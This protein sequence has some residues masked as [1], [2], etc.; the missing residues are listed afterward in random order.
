VTDT[1]EPGDIV[2]RPDAPALLYRVYAIQGDWG[3]FY[4]VTKAGRKDRRQGGFS[5]PMT[6]WE[7]VR[8]CEYPTGDR[9]VK[10]GEKATTM[11]NARCTRCN[12]FR[13]CPVPGCL[14]DLK[15]ASLPHWMNRFVCD[16]CGYEVSR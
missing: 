9:C 2:R 4:R 10:C 13:A 15:G 14:G 11:V 5:G 12:P 7:L 6:G 16:R 1:I 8:K 3:S